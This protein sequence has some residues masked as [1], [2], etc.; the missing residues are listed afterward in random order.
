MWVYMLFSLTII[1]LIVTVI[2]VNENNIQ[3]CYAYDHKNTLGH[4]NDYILSPS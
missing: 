1:T 2:N 3:V 4:L